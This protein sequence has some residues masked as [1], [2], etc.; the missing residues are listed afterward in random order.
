MQGASVDMVNSCQKLLT[1][2][3][4]FMVSKQREWMS[5]NDTKYDIWLGTLPAVLDQMLCF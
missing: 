5:L 3:K 4:C 1:R 2:R